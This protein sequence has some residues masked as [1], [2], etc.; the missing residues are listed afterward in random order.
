MKIPFTKMHGLGN[1]FVIIESDANSVSINKKLIKKIC[2]RNYGVGCDQLLL[3]N[4]YCKEEVDLTIFNNDVCRYTFSRLEKI[5]FI[6]FFD[7]LIF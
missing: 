5:F 1:D 4:S 7:K 2:S 6:I 3:I